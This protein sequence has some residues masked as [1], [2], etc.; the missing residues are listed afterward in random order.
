MNEFCGLGG[1]K[2][3]N[4]AITELCDLAKSLGRGS[5][6]DYLVATIIL[7]LSIAIKQNKLR[8][9][10]DYIRAWAQKGDA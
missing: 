6:D 4:Y 3:I 1:A 7:T 10:A 9:F 5:N 8:D 2:P